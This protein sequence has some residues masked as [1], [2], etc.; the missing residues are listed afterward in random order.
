[1]SNLLVEKFDVEYGFEPYS[2]SCDR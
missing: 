1:L 2:V